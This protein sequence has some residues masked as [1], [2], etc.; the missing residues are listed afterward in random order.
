MTVLDTLL[1]KESESFSSEP[2]DWWYQNFATGLVSPALLL[3]DPNQPRRKVGG[4]GDW[5]EFTLAIETSGVRE[6]IRV[7]PRE[8]AP[9]VQLQE[10][11]SCPFIIVSGHR[12]HKAALE[13]GLEFVPIIVR[14]YQNKEEYDD[15]ADELNTNR[16][17]Y[18]ALEEAFQIKRRRERGE[19]WAHIA[20][21]RGMSLG[22][23]QQ[24]VKLLDLADDIKE[25]IDPVATRG[26]RSD[27]PTNVAQA[28]GGYSNLTA[29]DA[30]AIANEKSL[31]IHILESE[32]EQAPSFALQRAMLKKIQKESM[33]SVLALQFLASGKRVHA[34]RSGHHQ[35]AKEERS[36]DA[37]FRSLDSVC[38]SIINAQTM[39]WGRG[40]VRRACEGKEVHEVDK[41]IANT[42]SS[43]TELKRLLELLQSV[44]EGKEMASKASPAKFTTDEGRSLLETD[45]KKA[46]EIAAK[47][48]AEIK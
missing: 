39:V 9:W 13:K 7:T 35:S 37:R 47:Y 24:R 32:G 10:E 36:V 17:N 27:F 8:S 23:V 25:L 40:D 15:D 41:L 48:G 14:I 21:A 44:K 1:S 45:P 20:A 42:T 43:I 38:K 22:S 4:G 34:E 29:D 30:K 28:L 26:K 46:A 31:E 16:K 3:P 6:P 2:A 18:T 33:G 11:N 5:E 12:R 19:K